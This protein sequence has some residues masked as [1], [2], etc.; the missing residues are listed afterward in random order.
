MLELG[1]TP[2]SHDFRDWKLGKARSAIQLK[3]SV[4]WYP[5]GEYYFSISI[6]ELVKSGETIHKEGQS[7]VAR[8][9]SRLL[10]S[11]ER[12]L[13]SRSRGCAAAV[14]VEEPRVTWGSAQA[15]DRTSKTERC[16]QWWDSKPDAAAPTDACHP[17]GCRATRDLRLCAQTRA[18]G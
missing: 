17:S 1:A 11:I 15:G 4:D 8:A 14:A 6:G 10:I 7:S 13:A 2:S 3:D 18:V 12:S 9:R 16:L 5:E